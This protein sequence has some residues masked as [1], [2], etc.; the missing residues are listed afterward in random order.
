MERDTYRRTE[1]LNAA[2]SEC[3]VKNEQC[4][5]CVRDRA[6]RCNA[7]NLIARD[8][9]VIRHPVF[10]LVR[11]V[12]LVVLHESDIRMQLGRDAANELHRV[13]DDGARVLQFLADHRRVPEH[14]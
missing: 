8:V 2:T 7:F 4:V 3:T 14:F 6:D 5:G 12:H 1:Q 10:A 9:S 11:A 13:A